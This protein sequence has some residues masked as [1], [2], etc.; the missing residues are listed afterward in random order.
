MEKETCQITGNE[1]CEDCPSCCDEEVRKDN[2]SK[3][4]TE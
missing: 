4:E 3:K 2:Y 1:D